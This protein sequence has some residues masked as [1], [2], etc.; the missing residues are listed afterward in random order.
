MKKSV[1]DPL[2]LLNNLEWGEREDVEFK[3]ARGGLPSSLWETYSAMANTHG[4]VILLGVEDDL[5]VSGVGDAA[6]LT[7]TFWDTINNRGKVNLNLLENDDL[8]TIEIDAKVVMAI[9]IPQANRYQKPVYLGQNP[10]L[11]TYRRNYTGDYHCTEQEVA[12]M[13]MDRSEEPPDSRILDHFSMQEI[14]APSLQQYRQRFSAYKPSHPWLDLDEKEL[15]LK[16]GG[17]RKDRAQQKEG[18]TVAGLLMFGHDEA[19]REAVPAFHIDYRERLSQDPDVRWTDRLTADGTWTANLF[20]FFSRIFHRLCADLKT[21]FQLDVN[22]IRKTDTGVHEAIREALVN[23]LIHAD[24]QGQGGIVVEKYLDRFEFSNPG[25][26]LVSFDQMLSGGVSECRNKSLQTMFM[27]IGIAEKAGSGIDKILRGWNSQHWRSPLFREQMQPDRILW[28]LPMVSLLPQ[29]SLERLQRRFGSAFK[30][31]N[32]TEV[33]ALVTADVEESVDNA[34]MRQF[35]SL[36]ASDVTKLLQNLVSKGVLV[37]E[38]RGR[39][40]QYRLPPCKDPAHH[41]RHSVHMGVDSVHMGVDSVH[42]GVDSVH[43]EEQSRQEWQ[44]LLQK[45]AP[46]RNN[47]RLDPKEMEKLILSLCLDR[48]LSRKQLGELLNRNHDGL[49]ARF[50]TSMVQH[51]LLRLRYPDKPNRVDQA[52]TATKGA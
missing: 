44:L 20:Q 52:Y 11:G 33:Q 22:L 29:D 25:T 13:L 18:L 15:L 30:R 46:A 45:A 6:K 34:R 36:H 38:K 16:L 9:R 7:K 42:M 27:M 21:P 5:T 26:S 43:M 23:A 41:S 19:I 3:S 35:T 28:R 50:L 51:G 2:T 49:R 14:D 8:K 47:A 1:I 32:K 31:F 48:W 37:Q 24:Y 12:R 17:W 39:W 10:S 40:S 4:G